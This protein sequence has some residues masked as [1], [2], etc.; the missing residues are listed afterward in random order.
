MT[1]RLKA[2]TDTFVEKSKA[3]LQ[4]N[5]TG[6]Y[7]HGSAAMG[8]YNDL[9]SDID[10]I[11]V[12][13]HAI[14]VADKLRFMQMIVDLNT[15]APKKGLEISVVLKNVCKP[16]VYP[17]PFELHFS[18]MHLEWFRRDPYDY[19]LN[20]NGIDK[21]LAAHFKV[22]YHR[23][24]CLYGEAIKDVFEDVDDAAYFDS[25]FGDIENAQD[26]IL[27]SPVYTILNLCR[28]LA[29]KREKLVLS[30][31]EGGRWGLNNLPEKYN[32]LI[33]AALVDY[34]SDVCMAFEKTLSREF[35]MY[36]LTEIK[37]KKPT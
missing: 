27:S 26:D 30:K 19:V 23:G 5:L 1:D 24:I 9:K 2:V 20:M 35:A 34:S 12:V 11:V 32:D 16:F 10:L 28:V 25:I 6:I 4:G 33:N 37:D 3:I 21:D 31:P 18:N 29:F 17:T 8:C 36:M 7:L 22:I 15:I 14:S 13:N